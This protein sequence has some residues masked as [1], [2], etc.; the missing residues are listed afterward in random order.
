MEP[1]KNI[2]QDP[3]P[4]TAFIAQNFS[5]VLLISRHEPSSPTKSKKA[6]ESVS[7]FIDICP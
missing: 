5:K 6:K 7:V 2:D 4:Y 1:N 3:Y